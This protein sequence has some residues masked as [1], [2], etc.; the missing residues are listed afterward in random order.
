MKIEN[1]KVNTWLP[2]FPGFYYTIFD[3][4]SEVDNE[5]YN[6]NETREELGLP[7]IDYDSVN[8]DYDSYRDEMAEGSVAFMAEELKDYVTSI[9]MQKLVS[10]R[11]YN[12]TNDSIN[13]EVELSHKNKR[14]IMLM[15]LENRSEWLDYIKETYT[16]RSGFWSYY[17][18]DGSEWLMDKELLTDDHKL[19]AV[20]EFLC[21]CILC[22]DE[23]SMYY[24]ASED[25]CLSVM[26]Y[27]ELTTKEKK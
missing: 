9:K 25:V 7:E 19:G 17:S 22:I 20:L 27:D 5:I 10:P 11:E 15:L 6:I 2:V 1:I 14:A 18:S 3:C 12:F 26:N 16:S 24:S 23:E 4:D 13:I 8:F 21:C